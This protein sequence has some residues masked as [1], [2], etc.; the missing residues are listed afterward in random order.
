MRTDTPARKRKLFS[1]AKETELWDDDVLWELPAEERK[2]VKRAMMWGRPLPPRLARVA[3]QHA[4]MMQTQAWYGRYLVTLG[5][6]FAG[7]TVLAIWFA[8]WAGAFAALAAAAQLL[9]GVLWLRAVARARR[10][11]REERWPEQPPG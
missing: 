4:S 1:L 6:V 5:V 9:N 11:V 2:R 3:V 8:G 10:A 7:L